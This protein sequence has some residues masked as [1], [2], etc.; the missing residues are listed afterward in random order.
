VFGVPAEIVGLFT[1]L[2]VVM[3]A[4]SIYSLVFAGRT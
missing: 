1:S 2:I 4:F 3:I